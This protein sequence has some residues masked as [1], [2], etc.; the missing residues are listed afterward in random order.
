M[1]LIKII[2][3]WMLIGAFCRWVRGRGIWARFMVLGP[4]YPVVKFLNWWWNGSE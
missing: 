1:I 4:L 2:F 3:W